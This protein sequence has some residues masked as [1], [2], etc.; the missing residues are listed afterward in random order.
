MADAPLVPERCV[1][2]DAARAGAPAIANVEP[3]TASVITMR[4]SD[5][6]RRAWTRVTVSDERRR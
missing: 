5:F 2:Q 6:M 4:V 1:V 3:A